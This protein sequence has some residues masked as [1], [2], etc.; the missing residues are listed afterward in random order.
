M[1]FTRA[2]RDKRYQEKKRARLESLPKISCKCGCGTQIPPKTM[3]GK[4]ARFACGHN[5]RGRESWNKGKPGPK[6]AASYRW[7]GG[8]WNCWGY[9]RCTISREVAGR[10][11]TAITGN[12]S[13]SI[14]RSHL[15][16]NHTH[17]NGLV[18]PGDHVHHI[19]KIRDDDR[20]ENLQKMD[21]RSHL[22]MH[23]R[24][25]HPDNSLRARNRPRNHLGQF[26]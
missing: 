22:V 25:N 19:N 13:S 6:G 14:L 18:H 9:V 12:T 21:R 8:E 23:N 26:I 5:R 15:V 24:L 1:A 7:K 11:P 2:E 3:E 20:L 10:Y 17:P 4:D 16:W